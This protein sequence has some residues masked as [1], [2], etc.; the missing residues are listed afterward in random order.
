MTA[1][2]SAR[3][4]REAEARVCNLALVG[5]LRQA[6][7]LHDERVAAAFRA[8]LRH[9]F[10]P[11]VPLEAV[12]RDDA[13]VTK[14]V[15]GLPHSSSSQPA[16]MA[17]ML[18]RLDVAPGQRVLEIGAGTGYNAA[19]LAHLA[20]ERGRVVTV[21]IDA[22]TV[23]AAREHLR[24][25]GR[26]RVEV[27][28]ADGGYGYPPGEPYDRIIVTVGAADLPPAWWEQ[29]RPGG[30][31]VV[32]LALGHHPDLLQLVTFRRQPD[33]LASVAIDPCGFMPC[34]APSPRRPCGW[35]SAP[36]R[37]WC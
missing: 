32:P 17:R 9:H 18:E 36:N 6:G 26:D 16:I 12:Y 4:A 29:L 10:L 37:R 24:A 11:G 2:Q 1:D 19:L 20:G 7:H 21:D 30:R 23:E 15:D 14:T 25:A 34:A 27:I 35:S 28:C 22:D 31:L 3:E 33:H 13:V 8:V 5:Q